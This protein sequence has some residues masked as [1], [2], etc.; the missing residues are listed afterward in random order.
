MDK[1]AFAACM[2]KHRERQGFTLE[3]L[4]EKSGISAD[5]LAEFESGEFDR[6]KVSELEK[7][8]K[9]IEVP[10]VCLMNGGGQVHILQRIEDG[11]T[12]CEWVDY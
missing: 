2:K 3:T 1:K 10:P 9:V 5:K 12:Y 8:G 11:K 7:I 6:I 4:A